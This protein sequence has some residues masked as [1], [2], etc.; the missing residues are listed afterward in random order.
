MDHKGAATFNG[1]PG[2]PAKRNGRIARTP[3]LFIALYSSANCKRVYP[4]LALFALA[5]VSASS[6]RKPLETINVC[7]VHHQLFSA[8]LRAAVSGQR[9][10]RVGLAIFAAGAPYFQTKGLFA[11][12]HPVGLLH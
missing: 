12:I 11:T 1:V 9:R 2:D 5:S 10:R 4:M 7:V 8:P 6:L 3:T